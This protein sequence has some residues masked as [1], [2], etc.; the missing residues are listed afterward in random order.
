MLKFGG[1][2]L[3]KLLEFEDTNT[4]QQSRTALAVKKKLDR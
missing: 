1:H 2:E 4:V 3:Q